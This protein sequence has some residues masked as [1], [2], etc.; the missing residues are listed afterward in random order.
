MDKEDNVYSETTGDSDEYPVREYDLTA[1]PNDFNVLTMTNFVES[2][3]LK[4]PG[5]QRNYVWDLKRAS[6][7]IESLIIGLPVPQLFLYEE[8]KNS[9]LV[10]DGHQRLMTIYYFVKERFPRSEMRDEIRRIFDNNGK[11]PEKYFQDDKYF[12]KFKLS[13]DN[14]NNPKGQ[15]SNKFSNLNFSTLGEVKNTFNLRTIRNVIVKSNRPDDDSGSAVFELFNRLNTGGINL[16][17]QEI[18]MSLYHSDFLLELLK[19]NREDNWRRLVSKK[20][21]IHLR[22]VEIILRALAMAEDGDSYVRPMTI[23]INNFAKKIKKDKA[24]SDRLIKMFRTFLANSA[25]LRDDTFKG[26]SHVF[27]KVLFESVFVAAKNV[28]FKLDQTK[29]DR[30]KTDEKFIN[31]LKEQTTNTENVKKRIAL[32]TQTLK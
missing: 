6:K 10:V 19:I 2:G 14:P 32:A 18:R 20:V 5:F 31:L 8:G 12:R 17:P 25:N 26:R 30:L 9:Y 27:Q 7:L 29:I 21:D 24:S 23:F 13:L 11:I 3:A 1:S 16:Y 15:P 4:I 28:D 22:D